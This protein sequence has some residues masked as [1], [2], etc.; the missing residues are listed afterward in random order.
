MQ[1]PGDAM[2]SFELY[3]DQENNA[4]G[5]GRNRGAVGKVVGGR[6]GALGA[7]A[8]LGGQ[9]AR[10]VLGEISNV[11]QRRQGA[12]RQGAKQV[13]SFGSVFG[14]DKRLLCPVIICFSE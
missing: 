2:A 12:G 8:V 11:T 14:L 13:L 7:R 9:G 10:A 4:P 6:A 5:M 1:I 3:A